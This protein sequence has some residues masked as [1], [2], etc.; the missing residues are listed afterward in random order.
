[1]PGTPRRSS[2]SVIEPFDEPSCFAVTSSPEER[3]RHMTLQELRYLVALAD[4]G[5][6]VRAA[7]SCN[8]GQPTLSTQLK[9]LEDYLGVTL[10]ERNKHHLRPTP[11]GEQII[12]RARLA[13]T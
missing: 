5:H 12:E 1:M 9:K 10:F 2:I 4:K 6:F 8:V 13:L 3:R 7:E 11:I